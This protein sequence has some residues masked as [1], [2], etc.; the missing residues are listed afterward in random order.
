MNFLLKKYNILIFFAFLLTV[1]QVNAA[2]VILR[3][4]T[5]IKNIKGVR[6]LGNYFLLKDDL[7]NYTFRKSKISKIISSD[8]KTIFEHKILTAVK[9]T[10]DDGSLYYSFFI[11][12][13]F[14]GQ[15][16]WDSY[17]QFEVTEGDLPD[18]IYKEYF[19]TGKLKRTFPI[20]DNTLDGVSKV[21]YASGMVAREGRFKNGY[22]VGV[23]KLYYKSGE[24]KGKS[25]YKKG[26]R[27]GK[28]LLYYKSGKLKSEMTF[29]DGELN[30][31][32]K[33]Y[34]KNGRISNIVSYEDGKKNG[35][36]KQYY[37]NGKLKV[38]GNCESGKLSGIITTYYRSGRVKKRKRFIDGR[39]LKGN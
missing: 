10:E 15:G 4:G 8:G 35:K 7:K 3:D 22:E 20:K 34:F 30:G 14:A 39:I 6:E 38:S 18:G 9:K 29:V 27:D 33:M 24:L 31:I 16:G 1:L 26:V 5:V 21:Y 32:Q 36:F 19:N 12:G 11:N 13:K 37:E 2:K 23:S 28:T 25:I 17:N